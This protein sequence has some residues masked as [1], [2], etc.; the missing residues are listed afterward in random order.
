[1]NGAIAMEA[2][3]LADK[4]IAVLMFATIFLLV[5]LWLARDVWREK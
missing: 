2:T 3:G 5:L 4:D 1:M